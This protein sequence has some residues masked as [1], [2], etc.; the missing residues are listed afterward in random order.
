MVS[1]S[2]GQSYA[3]KSFLFINLFVTANACLVLSID[4]FV[5]QRYP[6]VLFSGIDF[7]VNYYKVDLH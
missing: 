2:F 3:C 5:F 6:M 7:M 4:A 1:A